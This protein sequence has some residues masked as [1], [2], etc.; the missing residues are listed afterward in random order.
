MGLYRRLIVRLVRATDLFDAS[1]YLESNPDVAGAGF[2]PLA[3]FV[4]HGDR[5]GREPNP[6]FDPTHYRSSAR[7]SSFRGINSL[8]HY[9]LI[10]RYEGHSVSPWFDTAHYLQQNRD[11]RIGDTNPLLHYL[12]RGGLESRSPSSLFDGTAYLRAYPDVAQ[13]GVNPLVHY[14]KLGRLEGRSPRPPPGTTP[15]PRLGAPEISDLRERLDQLSSSVGAA[16]PA[17]DVVVPVHGD[18]AKTLLCVYS[19]L[20]AKQQTPFELVVINDASPV[21]PL[22]ADLRRLAKRG[23]LTYVENTENRGFVYSANRGI[24]LHAGRD[25]VLLNSDTEVYNDWLDRLRGAAYRNDRNGTVTPLSNNATICSYP[26]FNRDNPYPLE[27][28]YE[29]LDYLAREANRGETVP[30]PTGVGFCL[31]VRRDCLNEIGSLD[32]ASFGHG[33]GEENDFCQR[34][35]KRAW[36]NVVACDVFVRH[37]GAA[38]YQGQRAQRIQHGLRTLAGKHPNYASDVAA[39]IA[40]DPLA[41]ARRRLDEARLACASG[42]R[43]VLIVTHNRGGGTERSAQEEA[44]QLRREETVV[45]FLRPAQTRGDAVLSSAAIPSLPNM[46]LFGFESM[47]PLEGALRSLRI[48]E[49]RIHH[50]IDLDARAGALLAE[51]CHRLGARLTMMLHDY[52]VICPRVNLVDAR[53]SYCGEP[54]V[55]SCNR[56]LRDAVRGVEATG[57]DSIERWRERYGSL[58]ERAHKVTVPDADVAERLRSYLPGLHL[59]VRPHYSLPA[60]DPRRQPL[61]R[62]EKLRVL[63]IGAISVIKGYQVLVACARDARRR[64]LPLEFAVMGYTRNDEALE[65]LGVEVSGRYS[66]E[67]AQSLLEARRPHL[68]WL[69]SVWPE[70][71]SYTLSLALAGG[72]DVAAFDLGAI[73]NR[74][75]AAGR[76]QFLQPAEWMN[77]PRRINDALVEYRASRI[78]RPDAPAVAL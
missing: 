32:E 20:A 2:N 65:R 11:V 75:R 31:Y 9:C 35:L 68:V 48:T 13:S 42:V 33:Y 77:A 55:E 44:R 8:L 16:H 69:P 60:G 41:S 28:P 63:L 39:F 76:A 49:I 38:S 17:I 14:I 50:L 18:H 62:D 27:L 34:A 59:S 45:Y 3:H 73:A 6:L 24:A 54:P 67:G 71:F 10:G 29:K 58:L 7:R 5:E 66:D 40:A 57:D 26:V 36:L 51:I 43:N 52:Y 72:Y 25:V 46:P 56:C 47:A 19:V 15:Q 74:L 4:A 37:W 64:K 53:G 23:L 61:E 30:A 78:A 1:Y 22:I 12:S 70:T 21:P